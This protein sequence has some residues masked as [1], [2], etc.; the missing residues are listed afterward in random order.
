MFRDGVRVRKFLQKSAQIHI[1]FSEED[2]L[3]I[4]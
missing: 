1:A 2:G 4:V 3:G